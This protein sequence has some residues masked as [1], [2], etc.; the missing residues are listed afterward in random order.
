MSTTE[1]T[2]VVE[3]RR[4]TVC[5]KGGRVRMR[6]AAYDA[7]RAG[8]HIQTVAP[9]LSADERE[10]LISGTHGPCWV[11]LMGPDDEEDG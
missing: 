4:C 8:G 6:K 7:W 10:Q 1:Q 2:V 3:T 9:E 5:G 11:E